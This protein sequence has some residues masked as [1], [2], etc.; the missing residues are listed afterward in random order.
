MIYP[1]LLA[2]SKS[3]QKIKA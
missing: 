3:S 2:W 1:L